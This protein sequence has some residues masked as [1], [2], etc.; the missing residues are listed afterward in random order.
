MK[1]DLKLSF[2]FANFTSDFSYIG[3]VLKILDQKSNTIM[4]VYVSSYH[5][6]GIGGGSL[7]QKTCSPEIW[8]TVQN[9]AGGYL[10]DP[11]V[12]TPLC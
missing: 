5:I 7:I 8:P 4:L 3:L 9:S 12:P 2:K 10:R 6:E 11:P 1:F